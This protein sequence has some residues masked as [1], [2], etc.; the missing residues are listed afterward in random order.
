VLLINGDRDRNYP[1]ELVEE[2]AQLIPD[3]TLVWYPG[4]GHDTTC[5]SRRLGPVVLDY[6][7]KRSAPASAS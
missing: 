4:K 2:T 7:S 5:G 3:C 6:I 1:K